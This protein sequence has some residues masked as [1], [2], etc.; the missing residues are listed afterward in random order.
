ME[1]S[2][3]GGQCECEHCKKLGS[4]SDRVFGLANDVAKDVAKKYPGKMVGVLAYSE[5]SE[6]PCFALEP[7]VYVQ[8]TAGFTRGRYTHDELLELWPKKCKNLG[9]YEYFSVWLWD[10]DRLPGGNGANL[11]RTQT[12]IDRYVE[13]GATSVD[14]ESGNNWGAA[15]PRVLRRQQAAVEPR[16]GRER[17]PGRLLRE[18]VRPGARRR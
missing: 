11:T 6:P 3:G 13:A 15:R 14:A 4:V 1:C 9:F 18:G 17:D 8:L 5:H 7:N 10:F 16:R 12:M 2:D